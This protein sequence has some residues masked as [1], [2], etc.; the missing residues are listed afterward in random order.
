MDPTDPTLLKALSALSFGAAAALLGVAGYRSLQTETVGTLQ[1]R[2]PSIRRSD[3]RKRALERSPVFA[4]FL[5]WLR[6][7]AMFVSRMALP[8]LRNYVRTPYA[9]AGY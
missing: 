7:P 6:A 4:F 2:D 5:V 3:Q 9:R 1:P 8:S